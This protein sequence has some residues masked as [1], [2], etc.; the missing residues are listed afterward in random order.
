MAFKREFR[1]TVWESHSLIVKT[2]LDEL[3]HV[4]FNMTNYTEASSNFQKK[5]V[6]AAVAV[7]IVVVDA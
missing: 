2:S 1:K 3:R 7:V 6:L 4:V 5:E